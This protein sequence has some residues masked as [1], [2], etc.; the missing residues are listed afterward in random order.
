[1]EMNGEQLIPSPVALVW[2]GLNDP[3]V[4][5]SCING[6]KILESTSESEFRAEIVAAVGPVK[7]KFKG[8]LALS[9]MVPLKSYSLRF[10]GTGGP[11]GF[12]KGSAKVALEERLGSTLL[13]YSASFNIGGITLVQINI[14]SVSVGPASTGARPR[15]ASCTCAS[16]GRLP[17]A[18]G[19]GT[20][21]MKTSAGCGV[22]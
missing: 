15:K 5:K 3:E 17:S 9:E 2:Q 22:A 12:V 7:A 13:I 20:A 19:V 1:M 6:C 18:S 11:A 8:N 16:I 14:G 4:L 21:M 10:E